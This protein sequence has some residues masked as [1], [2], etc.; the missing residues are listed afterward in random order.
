[1]LPLLWAISTFQKAPKVAQW[2]S[3]ICK[4]NTR[5]LNVSGLKAGVVYYSFKKTYNVNK[6]CQLKTG[7]SAGIW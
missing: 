7:N 1:M 6:T 3:I 5:W 4:H 2:R